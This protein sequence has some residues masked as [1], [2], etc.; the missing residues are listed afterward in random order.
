MNATTGASLTREGM[1]H[2]FDG[3][4]EGHC[5]AIFVRVG[6]SKGS[7]SCVRDHIGNRRNMPRSLETTK[8]HDS[9]SSPM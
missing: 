8:C 3:V 7:L 9:L 5:Y 6:F 4:M 2:C 1:R